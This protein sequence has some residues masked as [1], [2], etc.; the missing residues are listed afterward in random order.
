MKGKICFSSYAYSPHYYEMAIALINSCKYYHPEIPF[1]FFNKDII[2]HIMSTKN[3]PRS[4][5]LPFLGEILSNDFDLVI[6]IDADSI[7][8]NKLTELIESDYDFASVRNNNDFGWAGM[9]RPGFSRVNKLTGKNIEVLDYLNAGL[10]ASRSKEFWLDWQKGNV[11]YAKDCLLG[12]Q[13]VMND[14]FYSGKYKTLV[15]DPTDKPYYYGVANSWGIDSHY[16][17]WK[18]MYIKEDELYLFN[19]KVNVLHAASGEVDHN[20]FNFTEMF[21]S[22]VTH[23]I[24]NKIKE[25]K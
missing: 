7:V 15:M 4:I 9:L 17:S 10:H 3:I 5:L 22:E 11:K 20:K 16:E 25:R 12:D 19:K 23:W 24:G 6:H 14:V 18:Q 13:D 8:T 1:V 2:D 21:R